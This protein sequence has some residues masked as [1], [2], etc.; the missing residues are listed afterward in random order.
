M[1][2]NNVNLTIS[3]DTEDNNL[4]QNGQNESQSRF[5]SKNQSP[6]SNSSS[7]KNYDTCSQ[8]STITDAEEIKT[9]KAPSKSLSLNRDSFTQGDLIGTGSYGKVFKVKFV[10]PD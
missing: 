6:Y 4:L 7:Y 8:N 10:D 5:S 9:S 3:I 2:R 1:T